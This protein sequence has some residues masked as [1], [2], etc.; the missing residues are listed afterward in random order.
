MT[1]YVIKALQAVGLASN[2]K[3]A[4]DKQKARLAFQ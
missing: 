1:W 4:S 2:V 3:L